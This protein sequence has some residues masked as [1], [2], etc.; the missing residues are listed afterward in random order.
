[1]QRYLLFLFLLSLCFCKQVTKQPIE[2]NES[3]Y[4]ISAQNAVDFFPDVCEYKFMLIVPLDEVMCS[5]CSEYSLK[6][7][8]E[9]V[10][11]GNCKI[12][13]YRKSNKLLNA[14][15]M[16][17]E[18]DKFFLLNENVVVNG[19]EKLLEKKKMLFRPMVLQCENEM[20]KITELMPLNIEGVLKSIK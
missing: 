8:S 5:S 15:L 7:A 2:S 1:M 14:I 12:V 6:W 16:K 4:S 13:I 10:Q 20:V 3:D 9:Y 17:K 19:Y 18:I 11:N